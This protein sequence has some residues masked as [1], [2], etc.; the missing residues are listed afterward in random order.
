[1]RNALPLY[2][3]Q[4]LY[5]GAFTIHRSS[6]VR[7][8]CSATARRRLCWGRCAPRVHR[9]ESCFPTVALG[10]VPNRSA[11]VFQGIPARQ[12]VRGEPG[13]LPLFFF[14]PLSLSSSSLPSPSLPSPACSQAEIEARAATPAL[15]LL[16]AMLQLR[17][18]SDAELSSHDAWL[19]EC[20]QA[21]REAFVPESDPFLFLG[22]S[23][24]RRCTTVQYST[25]QAKQ[26]LYC[27]LFLGSS[28][29]RRCSAAQ[30]GTAVLNRTVQ[31]ST[32]RY[33]TVQY[34]TE[35][36]LL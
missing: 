27:G 6:T 4:L 24:V 36:Q 18:D 32:L 11:L 3:G 30:R 20:R 9:P 12:P 15:R 28:Q 5:S 35:L 22:S 31:H 26:L 7:F 16:N 10:P 13:R 1:M 25:T 2:S 29:V 17:D 8:S 14:R 34:S 19:R 23:Q 21:M 33:S